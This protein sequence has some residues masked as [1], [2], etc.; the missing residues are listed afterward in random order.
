M[1]D[2]EAALTAAEKAVGAS[3]DRS[4][5]WVRALRLLVASADG[6]GGLTPAGRS[7][8]VAKI[9]LLAGERLRAEQILFAEPE[10]ARRP[11]AVRFAVA[12]MGRSGTT[13]LHRLLSCDPDVEFLATW[14]AMH[15]VPTYPQASEAEDPRRR[16]TREWVEELARTSP[17]T[18]RIH[19]IQADAPE[20][21]VF[22]LQHSFASMLFAL[23]APLPSYSQWLN[24][25]DHSAAYRFAL[26]LVRLNEWAAGAD[27]GRP[28]IMKSP[29][30]L[31]DLDVVLREM[32]DALVVQTH[33]DPLDLVGSYCSTYAASRRRAVENLDPVALGA[34]RLENLELMARRGMAVRERWDPARFCDVRYADLVGDPLGTV[35][36]IYRSAGLS[37][38]EAARDSMSAW[39]SANPQHGA[40]RHDYSLADY[41][42]DRTMVLER[43]AAYMERYGISVER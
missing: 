31:L 3:V 35:E 42:L 6:E 16:Q 1:L 39:L 41:G 7:Q 11:L 14:Q 26:D 18:L 2:A 25:T 34:E 24:G 4:A 5:D 40:G 19:P 22:L 30:F 23:S 13:L 36:R 12:G 9:E 21:E 10:I 27:A 28:R 43:F 8:L 17:E 33:R 20:E 15:P 32:P 29:Q 38:S 37:V